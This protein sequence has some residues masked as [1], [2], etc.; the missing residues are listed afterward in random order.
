MT[1]TACNKNGVGFDLVYQSMAFCYPSRPIP[2]LVEPERFWFSNSLVRSAFYTFKKFE[3]LFK[4]LLIVDCPVA[5]V[6][7]SLVVKG[8]LHHFPE[9]RLL[10]SDPNS[11]SEKET[12]PFPES[13]F[14]M[15]LL[16]LALYSSPF[17]FTVKPKSETGVIVI[18]NNIS[19]S[20]RA[21]ILLK[22]AG[23]SSP[24]VILIV[25]SIF[26]TFCQK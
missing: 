5:K 26:I 3:Y 15:A 10:A 14:S 1:F 25:V 20:K 24:G 17:S 22:R 9:R 2:R 13:R 11:V 7:K 21:F 4:N 16:I 19:S 23:V 12:T 18:S 6:F 8:K